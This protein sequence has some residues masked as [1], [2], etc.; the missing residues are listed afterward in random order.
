MKM[1]PEEYFF[2][3]WLIIQ[4]DISNE[5]Y[6]TLTDSEINSLK[7]EFKTSVWNKT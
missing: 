2:I 4:K 5:K 6:I 1:S 7:E 3:E